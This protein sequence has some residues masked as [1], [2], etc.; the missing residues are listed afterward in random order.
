MTVCL[1]YGNTEFEAEEM[2]NDGFMKV[3]DRISS[4]DPNR[5]FKPWFRRIM[6]NSAIDHIR[7]QRKHYLNED[8]DTQ[9][10]VS[11]EDLSVIDAIS[12]AELMSKVQELPPAYKSAFLL[13]VVEGFK[14]HEIAEKLGISEGTSKSNLAKAKKKLQESLRNWEKHG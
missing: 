10:S 9:L 13:Y 11:G 6:I 5:A 2:V 3:F 12:A 4:F 1:P 8:I 14:H 7:S